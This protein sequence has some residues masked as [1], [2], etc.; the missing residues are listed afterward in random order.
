M[1]AALAQ[2][3]RILKEDRYWQAACRAVDFINSHLRRDDGRLW[4]SY[5]EGQAGHLAYAADYAYLI[6]G[7]LELYKTGRDENHL[8]MAQQ[9]NQDMLRFFW[10]QEAGGLFFYGNDAETL[11]TR[12]KEGHDGAMPSANAVA[13]MNFLY[14]A[15]LTGD[16]E[17]EQK[18]GQ[19]WIVS[20]L[21]LQRSQLHI[22]I[23]F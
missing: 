11:L 22:P 20:L 1:I 17:L 5:R 12:P 9:F 13:A 4:A 23:G 18:A 14:L 7:L 8:A 2:G 6:W 3:A 15:R 16:E 10:D 21:R 19:T